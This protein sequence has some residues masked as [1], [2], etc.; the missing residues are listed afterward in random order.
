MSQQDGRA[1][2]HARRATRA[3]PIAE[4]SVECGSARRLR[5]MRFG[6][7]PMLDEPEPKF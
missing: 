1:E 3:A 6:R 4:A 7:E 2:T 5:L